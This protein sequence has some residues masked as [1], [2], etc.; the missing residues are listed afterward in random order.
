MPQRYASSRVL[1]PVKAFLR[2]EGASWVAATVLLGCVVACSVYSIYCSVTTSAGPHDPS[3]ANFAGIATRWFVFN[4]ASMLFLALLEGPTWGVVGPAAPKFDLF[5]LFS[6]Q[7][8]LCTR[9]EI[10]CVRLL[11]ASSKRVCLFLVGPRSPRSSK[12]SS[13]GRARF[14]LS[15][16]WPRARLATSS[17]RTAWRASLGSSSASSSYLTATP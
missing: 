4:V 8:Q 15:T 5:P 1:S 17:P 16:P 7:V 13:F 12:R 3:W 9:L 14:T 10:K 2:A 6:W 11:L